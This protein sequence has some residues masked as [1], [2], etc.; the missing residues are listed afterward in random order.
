VFNYER[1]EVRS[2]LISSAIYWLNEFH[3]DGLRVD[4]VASMLYLDFSRQSEQW[5]PNIHGGNENLEAVD[6]IRELNDAVM[7]E[8]PGCVMIA[9]ESTDW[10]RVTGPTAEG[11]LGFGLKWN[12]G[13]MHDSLDYFSKK[14]VH[15]KHHQELLTFGPVYAFNENFMLPLSHDEVVHLKKSL[16]GRMPG[17]E[18]QQF[19]NLRLLF[20]YQW[21][22]PGKQLLFMGGEFA[23]ESEWDSNTVLPWWRSTQSYPAGVS[24]LLA[25]LNR[26]QAEHKA[27]TQWDC[28]SRGFEWLSGDDKEQSIIAFCRWAE[29]EFLV[30]VLNFT[31]EPRPDYR[32]PVPVEGSYVEIFNSDAAGYQGSDMLNRE[33]IRSEAIPIN[34]REKSLRL[35]LPPLAGVLLRLHTLEV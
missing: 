20:T 2:F 12:M 6:F 30:V 25:D 27:L 33:S 15:R 28:D 13:W 26:L 11:G 17:D 16:F 3:L 8:C 31:P 23:Q 7:Q 29:E 22:Y 34:G 10:P 32:I 1:R 19:S 18:W 4:A 21:S 14:P 5:V 35:T 24:S 9:E